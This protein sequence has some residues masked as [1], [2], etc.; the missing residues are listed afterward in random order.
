MD[1]LAE[2]LSNIEVAEKGLLELRERLSAAPAEKVAEDR[3]FNSDLGQV[4]RRASLKG[5]PFL[6]FIMS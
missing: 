5:N 6:E 4:S 2:L 1:K 3:V